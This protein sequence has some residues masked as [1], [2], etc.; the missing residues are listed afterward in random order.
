MHVLTSPVTKKCFLVCR[1]SLFT[2]VRLASPWMVWRISFM[3]G[4]KKKFIHPKSVPDESEHSSFKIRGPLNGP[5][6]QNGEFLENC[7]D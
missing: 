1:L 5:K 2:Y 7:F 6:T 4:I 3:P